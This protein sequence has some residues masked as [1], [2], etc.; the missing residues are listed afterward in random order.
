M[1]SPVPNTATSVRLFRI[2]NDKPIPC[3]LIRF[4]GGAASVDVV[5][6][7]GSISGRVE[8]GGQIEDHFADL[9]DAHG[10]IVG[11]VALDRASYSALKNRWMRCRTE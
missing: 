8:I 4:A 10:D 6:R 2:V 1:L 5:L 11:T 9:L 7:R 3:Q